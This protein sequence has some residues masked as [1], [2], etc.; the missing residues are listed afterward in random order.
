MIKRNI[1]LENQ[2]RK[3][4]YDRLP[5]FQALEWEERK[6]VID[7]LVLGCR[8]CEL[9]QGKYSPVPSIIRKGSKT[10]VLGRNP[11]LDEA[12]SNELLPEGTNIKTLYNSYLRALDLVESD[13]S[14]INL[15]SCYK[16]KGFPP[17][18]SNISSCL[19]LRAL[20][21]ELL[22]DIDII[23]CMCND[24]MKAVLGEKATSVNLSL[25]KY[26]YKTLDNGKRVLVIPLFHPATLSMHPEYREVMNKVLNKSNKIIKEWR[27]R[28][29]E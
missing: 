18:S 21:L 8:N 4:I 14:V 13:V 24:G 23:L 22:P 2:V 29:N 10:L 15:V 9:Y 19:P 27:N 16:Y 26:F 12:K 7:K 1:A 20:E 25:G 28:I 11:N 5:D 6:N 3:F 17:T